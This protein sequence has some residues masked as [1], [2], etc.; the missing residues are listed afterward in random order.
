MTPVT[1]RNDY[2]TSYTREWFIIVMD[3]LMST[4]QFICFEILYPFDQLQC[5]GEFSN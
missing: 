4:K 1:I 5:F 2:D 3:T